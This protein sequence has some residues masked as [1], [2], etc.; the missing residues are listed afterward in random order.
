V[1]FAAETRR[2]RAVG[3]ATRGTTSRR[4][5]RRVDR[6]LLD[7][8]PGLV[9]T[10]G[11]LVVDLGFGATPVTTV[12]LH[13]LIRAANPSARVVGL[14][15]DPQRVQSAASW[16]APGLSFDRG[17]FEL[18]GLRPHVVRALNVLR[19][20]DEGDV[21]AAWS[22]MTSA[23]AVGGVVIEGS[24]D[25]NG[26]LGTWVTLGAEGARALT[27]AVDPLLP[28]SA[29]A[30][31]LPKALIHR[32]RPGEPVHRLITDFDHQ[33][34]RSASVGVFSPR[35]RLVAAAQGLS[36]L[37]WPILDGPARWRRGE[38]TVAWS[39]VRPADSR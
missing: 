7:H 16:V 18:A 21:G 30:A 10:S 32:N 33:W 38:L 14:E 31:R 17:G 39:A 11:L 5:L 1:P 24:C 20:Y 26:R 19:Q 3:V 8:H 13:A 2:V 34:Q 29:V 25:E 22:L 6:W 28:P 15:I 35:Q 27:L 12:A 37:G 9:R 4:R 23:L 36:A